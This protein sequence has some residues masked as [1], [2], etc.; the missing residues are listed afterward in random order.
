MFESALRSHKEKYG[1]VHHLVGT[2][3]H[4]CGIVHMVAEQYIQGKLCFQEAV[5]VRTAALGDTHPDVAVSPLQLARCTAWG[6][7]RSH[8]ILFLVVMLSLQASK[9]KIGMI[10]I[11]G[12]DYEC[13][14][15]TF[16]DVISQLHMNM[17]T[18]GFAPE[19]RLL[20]NIGVVLFELGRLQDAFQSFFRAYQI[21][22]GLL[23][24]P[25]CGPSS[26][27][28]LASTLSNLGFIYAEQGQYDDSLQAYKD[29][30]EILKRYYPIDHSLIVTVDEN[31][32]HV[33]A[34]GASG[35]DEAV[36]YAQSDIFASCSHLER[37]GGK[38]IRHG[39]SKIAACFRL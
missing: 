3:L 5:S 13:A 38:R 14:I 31:V 24:D 25:N 15:S 2:G 8:L 6:D 26:E 39:Q 18:Y 34:Y 11:A 16:M 21:Q 9:F 29:A 10:Q 23:G 35:G 27:R 36:R 30:I 1:D 17:S 19:A 7:E 22:R 32:A 12:G 4:N 20:N 37:K 33:R 28:S